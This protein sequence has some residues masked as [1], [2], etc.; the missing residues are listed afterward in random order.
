MARDDIRIKRVP[1]ILAQ[2][3]A[4]ELEQRVQIDGIYF[5]RRKDKYAPHWKVF[6][7]EDDP[8]FKDIVLGFAP[9]GD[10]KTL[11]KHALGVKDDVLLRYS[12][13]EIDKAL[14]PIEKGWAPFALAVGRPGRWNGAWPEV[15]KYHIDHWYYREDARRY[16]KDDVVYTRGLEKHFG[17]PEPGDDDSELAC[18]VAAVRWRGF[19]VDLDKMKEQQIAALAKA[20][21][22]PTAPRQ[23][24]YFINEVV[25]ASEAAV[26][27]GST[28]KIILEQISESK[29]DCF[30]DD[31][32]IDCKICYGT[33]VHPQQ[34]VLP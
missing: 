26:I 11:A 21:D 23:A 32:I 19:K 20:K 12:D 31:T 6:D 1:T 17:C 2:A 27:Q 13:I 9:K 25:S 24:A 5:A 3:L 10:L 14:F 4:D 8:N 22:I 15:I 33:K 7:I 28:K 29:C 30:Y 16:A 34:S 18:M